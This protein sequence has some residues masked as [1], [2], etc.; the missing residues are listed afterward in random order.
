MG[1]EYGEYCLADP[2]VYDVVTRLD[3]T[4]S[5][6]SVSHR[7]IPTG[8][9]RSERYIWVGLRPLGV[10]L[11][12]QGWKIHISCTPDNAE[13]V[14]GIAWDFCLKNKVAFKFIRSSE[15]LVLN[16]AKDAS[17]A[18]S[19][20]VITLYPVNEAQL[21]FILT[22]LGSSLEGY[23]GPY[24]LSD[25]RWG[26]GPLYV[27][28][29]GFLERYHRNEKGDPVPAIEGPD[30]ELVPDV[31]SP[32]FRVPPWAEIPDFLAAQIAD[33][34]NGDAVDEADFP[35]RIEKALHF[36]NGG[37]VYLAE[38]P[39]TGQRV[40]VR[41]ARPLAGLD[42]NGADAVTRLRRERIVLERLTGVE[43][44][45]NFVDYFTYWEHHFLV[46]EYVEGKILQQ[47]I[48]ERHPL[49]LHQP[50]ESEFAE[51][52]EWALK[53]L[54]QVEQALDALHRRGILYGDLHWHNVL[55]KPDGGV[56]LVDFEVATYLDEGSSP[57][58]G[59]H[60]FVSSTARTGL[61]VDDYALACLHLAMFLP[62]MF[63]LDKD[64][65]KAVTLVR[66]LEER[67]PVPRSFGRQILR[68]LGVHA[69]DDGHVPLSEP[70]M[71]FD[72]DVPDWDAVRT[73]II[74]GILASATP[75]RTDRLFPGD[76][77]Q[78]RYG[79]FTLAHGAAGVLYA[80]DTVGFN[81]DPLYTD[82]LIEATRNALFPSVGLYNGLH[83]VAYVL[84]KLG[85]RDESLTILDRALELSDDVRTVDLFGGQSGIA[86]N[87]LY[88]AYVTGDQALRD[89]ALR[90][91]E[92][93]IDALENSTESD[94]ILKAP[95][96]PGLMH[97]FSGPALLFIHLY[98]QTNDEAFLEFAASALR[99][100]LS[101]C[102][103]TP[104]GTL[105]VQDAPRVVAYLATGSAGI[106]MVL[107]RYLR[108]R[109]DDEF[110]E[111]QE[112]IKRA[113]Q[114]E[115]CL[116]PGLF[117][118]RAGFIAY[119]CHTGFSAHD[120]IIK[121]H[122]RRLAWHAM[123]YR[124]HLG[125]PGEYLLRLSMDLA[126]GSAGVMLALYTALRE[127]GAFLP[128]LDSPVER[129]L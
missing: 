104:D 82:W 123:P 58:L 85:L 15:M 125:F 7:P 6:V 79:G 107:H 44:A 34:A 112:Y 99:R 43:F 106:G 10:E 41:E 128:F 115:F 68:R 66:G 52:T 51:Y 38:N 67:F 64:P 77:E 121:R 91:V 113:C 86:L 61:S 4:H 35:Y 23:E 31:R 120:P 37:G 73:S 100:D 54:D 57:G 122:L 80:L 69:D 30:G 45:P 8:W 83:G 40:V 65:T 88:F 114:A 56:V 94:A 48:V 14:L 74:A 97:G 11:P 5:R 76:I 46:E 71:L 96:R 19:G 62:L 116:E 2:F 20:K 42:S 53:I 87:L 29:G 78:F 109:R 111:K 12:A 118:G 55:V 92:Q 39:S 28:Y 103:M 70:S 16:N 47:C 49:I 21:E 105:Q 119:L 3:D 102:K 27:R 98:E 110:A 9:Q 72:A 1:I 108:H 81:I 63:L 60:G 13:D 24:I 90:K 17:R 126:T 18:S 124:G 84:C 101:H 36:S 26:S 127:P 32:V 117:R 95:D 22:E 89:I 33:R 25:L 59:A 75:D 93:L 129:L 50:S